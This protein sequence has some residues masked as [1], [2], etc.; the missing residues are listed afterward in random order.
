MGLT[1]L[2]ASFAACSW[3]DDLDGERR[4]PEGADLEAWGA[5]PESTAPD[6]AHVAVDLFA[7]RPLIAGHRRGA[8]VIEAGSADFVK[9]IDGGVRTD[10]Y[11][12]LAIPQA[13]GGSTVVAA[14]AVRGLAAELYFPI[15]NDPSG[16]ER[17]GGSLSIRFRAKSAV[18]NQL[19]SVFLNEHK[20]TDL[21]MPTA[22]WQNYSLAASAS[23]WVVGENK[24][25]FYFRS[26]GEIEGRSSA[27]AFSRFVIGASLSD[28]RAF[29]VGQGPPGAGPSRGLEVAAASRLSYYFQLPES[30]SR[31]RMKVATEGEVSV[32]V[33]ESTA[34]V[35]RELWHGG[36]GQ[37]D[38]D[39]GSLRGE[40]VRLDLISKGAAVWLAPR[41]VIDRLTGDE[42][43]P[44][45]P[46]AD[47][48]VFWSVSSLRSDRLRSTPGR[49][50][51]R[52]LDEAF[53]VPRMQAVV[54]SA[55][56]ANASAML[57]RFRTRG[58]IEDEQKT[59]AER[60]Q[61]NGFATALISGNG[62]VSKAAGFSQGFAHY[63]NPM[64]RQHHF[65]ATTL[66]RQAKK[67]LLAHKKER[68]FVHIATVEGHIP[69]RPSSEAIE[70][71]WQLP[72]PFAPAKTLDLAAQLEAGRRPATET[73][74]GYVRALYDA[75][76]R[77][78]SQAFALMLEEL[79]ALHLPGNT[80]VVLVGEH[81]EEL[82]ERGKFG[83]GN[84]LFQESLATPL[85]IRGVGLGALP[86]PREA[87]TLDVAP[88]V[89]HLA[90]IERDAALQGQSV[91]RI[92]PTQAARPLFSGLP[93]GARSLRIGRYKLVLSAR[94]ELALFDLRRDAGEQSNLAV[95]RPIAVRALRVTLSAFV[96]FETT[97]STARWGQPTA[98]LEAFARDLGF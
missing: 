87:S 49:G 32:R 45:L 41:I 84:S 58:R 34:D 30:A 82:W 2:V 64:R 78:S 77:E 44:E 22:D 94:G 7:S 14:S 11:R 96:A 18:K 60:L 1:I 62:F 12:G 29:E 90:G 27:A 4:P 91:M 98:P 56:G 9:Y 3:R 72:A 59:L 53:V 95:D 51:E 63:D 16:I 31:L 5:A 40:I 67:F 10:W 65:G 35:S 25:R 57:G 20:I 61:Q 75:S 83:H 85:A 8:L 73:E 50:F 17:T 28:E 92:Q 71:H 66:W 21:R 79:E 86:A 70:R 13:E 46:K 43:A 6:S 93:S 19:V 26:A 47:R 37:V 68:T 89:L 15:D 48:I 36:Q 69:Y 80:V 76:I 55:G 33:R 38:L 39:L 88:T 54:P 97:W 74:K 81:G 24:L 52:F 42:V 23:A